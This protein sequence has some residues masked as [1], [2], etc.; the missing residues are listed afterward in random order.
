MENL[1]GGTL[2]LEHRYDILERTGLHGV[3]TL[4]HGRQDP[5]AKT[6]WVKA[7][8]GLSDADAGIEI[9]DRLRQTSKRVSHLD[10]PGVLR[11]IDYGELEGGIPFVISERCDGVCLSEILA[12]EGTL[13][14]EATASLLGRLASVLQAAHQ[15]G[16][17]HGSLSPRWIHVDE[18]RFDEAMIGHFQLT[19]TVAEILAAENEF[20]SAEA[21]SAFPPEM[22]IDTDQ[23]Q[24]S[25]SF[26]PAG[27][28]WSLG[29]LAYTAMVGVHPFFEEDVDPSEAIEGLRHDQ[30]RPLSE[31]GVDAQISDVVERALAKDPGDRFETVTD[32]AAAF[33]AA[34][35]PDVVS[36]TPEAEL[37]D[38]GPLLDKPAQHEPAQPPRSL[39]APAEREPGP[40]D[41]LLTTV[42]VLLVVS[43]LAWLL[44]IT[45]SVDEPTNPDA[46]KPAPTSVI[47]DG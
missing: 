29:V 45:G 5:F 42:I 6:V 41:R 4:Y 37:E 28:I 17:A 18:E 22:F 2:A 43:N 31:M 8:D 24:E 15:E 20:M 11:V 35:A 34:V 30:A 32:F 21:V 47:G 40:S 38:P 9:F 44:Y 16:I 10:T 46:N 14:A 39:D 12:S 36:D 33:D 19:V 1:Q 23:P 3:V 25:N 7:Y 27:D 26:E 13:S